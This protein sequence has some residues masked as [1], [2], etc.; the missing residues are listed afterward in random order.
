M[1]K[2]PIWIDDYEAEVLTGFVGELLDD[3][4]G[5]PQAERD[6][7]DKVYKRLLEIRG[8]N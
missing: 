2:Q 6:V 8:L 5:V 7:F 3:K 1:P 4:S